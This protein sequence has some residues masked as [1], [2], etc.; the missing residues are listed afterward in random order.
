MGKC[1]SGIVGLSSSRLSRFNFISFIRSVFVQVCSI[2]EQV[3]FDS[4]NSLPWIKSWLFTAI[5][6]DAVRKGFFFKNPFSVRKWKCLSSLRPK[7]QIFVK[8]PKFV[9]KSKFLSKNPN[10]SQIS[11]FLSNIEILLKNRNSSQK[12]ILRTKIQM[13]VKNPNLGR[14]SKL[15]IKM[16][17]FVKNPFFV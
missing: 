5:T 9:Q 4:S 1:G 12:S 11:K 16:K 2:F 14:K 13:F 15:W 7:I 17:M 10:S 3:I 8:N 6:R